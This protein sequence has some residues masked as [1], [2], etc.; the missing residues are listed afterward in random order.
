MK[1]QTPGK[2][3]KCS[4]PGCQNDAV[5]IFNVWRVCEEC[6][7]EQLRKHKEVLA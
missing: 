7:M 1:P 3:C 4:I 6:F 5:L 2:P